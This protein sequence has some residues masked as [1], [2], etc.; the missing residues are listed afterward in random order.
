MK[1]NEKKTLKEIFREEILRQKTEINIT[2]E[3]AKLL[4][5]KI[6]E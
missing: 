6:V 2:S 1:E 4:K 5:P 3:K